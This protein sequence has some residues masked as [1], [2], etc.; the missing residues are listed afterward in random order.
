MGNEPGQQ[1]PGSNSVLEENYSS[2]RIQFC[3]VMISNRVGRKRN[4]PLWLG[5][6]HD[7]LRV[8]LLARRN[9]S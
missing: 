6:A 4:N 8:A 5:S 1:W 3:S 9:G 2:V 7:R